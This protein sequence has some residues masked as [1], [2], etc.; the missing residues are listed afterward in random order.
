MI[1]AGV[2]TDPSYQEACRKIAVHPG[3]VRSIN[4]G[5][6]HFI[7]FTQLCRLSGIDPH[8][9]VR[10]DEQ[11][12]RGRDPKDY[13]HVYPWDCGAYHDFSRPEAKRVD[14]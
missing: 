4:D 9:A 7:S 6:R 2:V 8:K 1:K 14:R 13:H 5:D 3:W 11:G 12:M 10:W